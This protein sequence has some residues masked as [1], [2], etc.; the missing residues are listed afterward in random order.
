[1]GYMG[2]AC[3]AVTG[4][5]LV[6]G[7]MYGQEEEGDRYTKAKN[8]LFVKDFASRFRKLN[9][10]ISCKELIEYDLSDEKQLITARQTDVFKTKCSKYVKDAVLILEE[11]IKEI[12]NV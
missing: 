9:G 6:L 10:S 11:M 3:G 5:F 1:M 4:A 8:Y 2:E 7:L 12:S